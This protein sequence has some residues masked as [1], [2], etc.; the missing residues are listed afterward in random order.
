ML[1]GDKRS[2]PKRNLAK[3]IYD[4]MTVT[5]GDKCPF[6]STVKNCI[7]GFRTGH[8]TTEGEE[9][10][11][12]QAQVTVAENLDAIHSLYLD[13]RRISVIKISETLSISRERVGYIIHEILDIKKLA[14]KWIPKYINAIQ[15]QDQVLVHKPFG[16]YFGRIVWHF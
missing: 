14:D 5:L 15:K 9:R 4:G 16:T 12:R 11:V 1:S 7:T 8:L 10:Y 6:Y 2:F 3:G 13:D